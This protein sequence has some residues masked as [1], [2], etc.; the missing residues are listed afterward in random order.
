MCGLLSQVVLQ[1]LILLCV[2]I[3]EVLQ[4]RVNTRDRQD[5]TRFKLLLMVTKISTQYLWHKHL[6]L[7][8]LNNVR[9][10]EIVQCN[11]YYI[12]I[13]GGGVLNELTALGLAHPLSTLDTTLVKIFSILIRLKKQNLELHQ[14]CISPLIFMIILTSELIYL[15]FNGSQD[16]ILHT[17]LKP[18]N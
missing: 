12:H 18:I 13:E 6:Q 2:S 15:H 3:V 7:G 4:C 8:L 11:L 1:H 16:L 9:Y 17:H 5:W 14:Y 10:S